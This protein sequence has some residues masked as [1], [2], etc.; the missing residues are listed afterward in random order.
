MRYYFN[1]IMRFLLGIIIFIKIVYYESY[2]KNYQI[3]IYCSERLYIYF[4]I[5]MNKFNLA[6]K[7]QEY[8]VNM[9]V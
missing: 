2:R 9:Y 4:K 5:K 1:K 6:L 3:R 8:A 7:Y